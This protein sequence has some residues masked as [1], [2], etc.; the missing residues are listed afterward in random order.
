MS[1]NEVYMDEKYTPYNYKGTK[2]NGVESTHHG[3]PA[4]KR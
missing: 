3:T 2:I 4:A 1:Q